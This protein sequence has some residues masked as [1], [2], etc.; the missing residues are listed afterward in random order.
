MSGTWAPAHKTKR[1]PAVILVPLF[2]ACPLLCRWLGGG[3]TPLLC[4][5][6]QSIIWG[7]QPTTRKRNLEKVHSG[8][9]RLGGETCFAA[10]GGQK[11][12]ESKSKANKSRKVEK[13]GGPPGE[14]GQKKTNR[15]QKKKPS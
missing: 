1:Q 9:G 13:K 5:G 3:K 15:K 10:T 11:K 7:E 4:V 8:G 2:S 12:W 6:S 14:S